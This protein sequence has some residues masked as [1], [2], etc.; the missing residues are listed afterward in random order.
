MHSVLIYN[1]DRPQVSPVAARYCDSFTCQLR[2]LTFRRNLPSGEGLMLV[3]GRDS[4]L[5]ASIHMLFVW[6]NLAVV[7]I[8][9]ANEVVDVKLARRWY[10]A[11][12]PRRPARYVLE[13][14]EERLDDFKIGEHV[15]F[16]TL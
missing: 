4:R 12:F 13:I 5:D 1:L 6:I 7:W 8:N 14:S 9:Q 10:P 11:Y 3:Q 2:G 16:D 15:R